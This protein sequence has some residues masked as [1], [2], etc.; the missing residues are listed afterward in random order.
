MRETRNR[1]G[2]DSTPT[3]TTSK[4]TTRRTRESQD[5][6]KTTPGRGRPRNADQTT[7]AQKVRRNSTSTGT[8]DVSG[9]NSTS[10]SLRSGVSPPPST[11]MKDDLQVSQLKPTSKRKRNGRDSTSPNISIEGSESSPTQKKS[12]SSDPTPVTSISGI[13]NCTETDSG[14]RTADEAHIEFTQTTSSSNTKILKSTDNTSSSSTDKSKDNDNEETPIS[15]NSDEKSTESTQDKVPRSRGRPRKSTNTPDLQIVPKSKPSLVTLNNESNT[16]SPRRSSRSFVPN[17]KFQDLDVE[18]PKKKKKTHIVTVKKEHIPEIHNTDNQDSSQNELTV[19]EDFAKEEIL[20][21]SVREEEVETPV[22]IKSISDINIASDETVV[23]KVIDSTKLANQSMKTGET[24]S[25]TKTSE[26]PPSSVQWTESRHAVKSVTYVKGRKTTEVM[27]YP[28]NKVTAP[29]LSDKANS[30]ISQLSSK[31]T[32][33]SSNLI[34]TSSNLKANEMLFKAIT[35]SVKPSTTSTISS[36]YQT[37]D[38]AQNKTDSW[39]GNSKLK[40]AL[41]DNE[42]EKINKIKEI[43]SEAKDIAMSSKDVAMLSKDVAITSKAITSKEVAI[44]SQEVAITSEEVTISSKEFT[45]ETQ[46]DLK[47]DAA[48]CDAIDDESNMITIESDEN[49]AEND[50]KNTG[51]DVKNTESYE[52]EVSNEEKDG[53]GTLIKQSLALLD[54]SEDENIIID[55]PVCTP[56]TSS[57]SKPFKPGKIVRP[58]TSVDRTICV[59]VAGKSDKNNDT[60]RNVMVKIPG[61]CSGSPLQQTSEDISSAVKFYPKQPAIPIKPIKISYKQMPIKTI[62]PPPTGTCQKILQSP[63]EQAVKPSDDTTQIVIEDPCETNTSV[64][65]RSIDNMA[66]LQSKVIIKTSNQTLQSTFGSFDP[67]S[68]IIKVEYDTDKTHVSAETQTPTCN[69]GK[70]ENKYKKV[71]R[72]I[73]SKKIIDVD[74]VADNQNVQGEEVIMVELPEGAEIKR[75]IVTEEKLEHPEFVTIDEHG[76]YQ[77]KFCSYATYKKSNWYKHKSKHLAMRSHQ[78][79]HCSYRAATSSNLKRHVAI[80]SDVRD[81]HCNICQ[82]NFRQKIHLERHLKYKHQEKTVQCP[83]CPYVC[84]N[85]NPDLKVHI[86]RR[87]MPMESMNAYTC[88]ECGLVTVSKKDLRQHMKFHRKGPELKLFCEHC[89]FVTDCESRLRRHLFIHTKEKPFQCGLCEYKG[90]QKEHVLRHMKSQHNIE[91]ERERS[92]RRSPSSSFETDSTQEVV[93]SN[94]NEK[95]DYSSEEKIFACNHCTMKFS[96]LIN[97]YKHLHTQHRGVMPDC[98]EEFTCVVCDFRTNNKKNLLVHMRKHNTQDQSPPSHVYSCVLCRYINPRRRNLFQHMKKKHHIEI[99]MKDDGSTNCFVADT[100]NVR[101]DS[102]QQMIGGIGASGSQNAD[103]EIISDGDGSLNLHNVI[104]LE[105]IAMVVSNPLSNSINTDPI[106]V[107]NI[108]SAPST[109]TSITEHE[110]A[111]AIEGLQAL[112]EQ[113]GLVETLVDNVI[114]EP[115]QDMAITDDNQLLIDESTTDTIVKQEVSTD[116]SD[117]SIQLSSDQ[118]LNLTSGDYVEINGEMYKVEIS[119]EEKNASREANLILTE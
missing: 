112:A 99:V 30:T 61:D 22:G 44:S 98:S 16:S 21:T 70:K 119:S 11:S 116:Q 14:K 38:T 117:Q 6:T 114:E 8:D 45:N 59:S 82:L 41:L 111:E 80:H 39:K 113:A 5:V 34:E 62:M 88:E 2:T 51:S 86:R 78:C 67:G 25:D 17:R 106:S 40:T 74:N 79:P 4:S 89:S 56:S 66:T 55:T 18:A 57:D 105:D 33:E 23:R 12:K 46:V 72:E 28:P 96:K 42:P 107:T 63:M 108:T 90:S 35:G 32:V 26:T 81:F 3:S 64:D 73:G 20:S 101:E 118:L 54:T 15:G 24:I 47:A 53:T 83:L 104:S 29:A 19:K 109:V 52:K 13:R 93:I 92:Y 71:F 58:V 9:Q 94:S 97:L 10:R 37:S 76:L 77:C 75:E 27:V 1:S 43:D 87:H 60:L 95:A 36:V 103:I 69:M 50:M 7:P 48:K 85:E 100:T 91:I 49:N 110:A 68:N 102:N 115:V 65:T 31:A 84:A